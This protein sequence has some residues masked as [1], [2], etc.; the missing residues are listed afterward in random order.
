MTK[1][2]TTERPTSI[3][4]MGRDYEIIYVSPT[5]LGGNYLG[6]CDN[7]RQV[8]YIEDYQTPVEEAD[9]VLHEVLHAIRY[10]A[11][12]EIDPAEEEKMVSASATGL[13]SVFH[14]N[15]GFAAWVSSKTGGLS[16]N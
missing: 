9:T 14:D 6:L 15:P 2:K 7:N 13:I 12:V 11:K 8:I 4:I 10:M 16:A 3:K 5:P 1:K